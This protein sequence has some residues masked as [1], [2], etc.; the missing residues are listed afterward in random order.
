[1]TTGLDRDHEPVSILVLDGLAP[2]QHEALV[3]DLFRLPR[4]IPPRCFWIAQN[5]ESSAGVDFVDELRGDGESL[6]IIIRG[7]LNTFRSRLDWLGRWLTPTIQLPRLIVQ[8]NR[9]SAIPEEF[10]PMSYRRWHSRYGCNSRETIIDISIDGA[11]LL[12]RRNELADPLRRPDFC[13]IDR[14]LRSSSPLTLEQWRAS[15]SDYILA[16]HIIDRGRDGT[17]PSTDSTKK[18]SNVSVER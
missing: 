14:L 9:P 6:R 5:T 8:H 13:Y 3:R 1:M 7:N 18:P 10:G 17:G 2:E 15:M 12:R 16:S 11:S 4:V